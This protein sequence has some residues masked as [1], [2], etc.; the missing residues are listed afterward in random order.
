MRE[1]CA[2]LLQQ[3][4]ETMS[5]RTKAQASNIIFAPLNK[6]E[7]VAEEWAQNPSYQGRQP[8]LHDHK[9]QVCME[10]VAASQWHPRGHAPGI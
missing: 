7:E 5:N 10:R 6:A 3:R 1:I 4:G 2:E 9:W 8:S